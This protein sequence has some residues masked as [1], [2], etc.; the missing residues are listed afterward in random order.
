M[1][2]Q[3]ISWPQVGGCTVFSRT[4]TH[5]PACMAVPEAV[6]AHLQ[7]YTDTAPHL[8]AEEGVKLTIQQD[9]SQGGDSVQVSKGHS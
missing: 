7:Q 6:V 3:L 1:R 8:C 9:L 4:Q 2:R 5:L